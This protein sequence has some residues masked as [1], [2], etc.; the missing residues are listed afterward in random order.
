MIAEAFHFRV[1]NPRKRSGRGYGDASHEGEQGV[2]DHRGNGKAAGNLAQEAIDAPVNVGNRSRLADEFSH[3]HEQRND[4][5]DIGADG[6]VGGGGQH[7][8]DR[9]KCV[10]IG[11]GHQPDT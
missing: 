7:G 8:L 3:Q 6:L 11:A 10:P 5:K 4:S 1:R 2:A 9:T